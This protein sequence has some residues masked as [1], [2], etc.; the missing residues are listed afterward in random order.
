MMQ[1]RSIRFFHRGELVA[2]TGAPPDRTVLEW[3][4]EDAGCHG[5]KE[6]CAEGDCGAC[7]VIV[8]ALDPLSGLSPQQKGRR[9]DGLTLRTVN[10]CLQFLPM[11]DGK[12]LYTIEDLSRSCSPDQ[13]SKAQLHPVQEAMVACHGSQCGFCTPGFVMSLTAMYED[14]LEAG[15]QPGRR[16]IADGL[17]GNLCRCTGYRPIIDAGLASFEAPI[18]R[19]ETAS[20]IAALQSLAADPALHYCGPNRSGGQSS[21]QFFAPR[22]LDELAALRE[23]MPQATLLAG[24]TDIGLW[25]NKQFRDLGD[26]LS[27]GSVGELQRI[28]RCDTALTIGAGVSL[29]LAWEALVQEWPE[30]REV[31]LR[32]AGPPVRHSG[33][34]GGNLANGSPIGDGAPVLMALD[35]QLILRK[36]CRVRTLALDSFYL[37]YRNNQLE[38]GEFLQAIQIP[39]REPGTLVRAWKISK[40]YDSDIS[41]VFGAF[42]LRLEADRIIEA[43]F[44]FGGMA[45]IVKRASQT[46]RAV[47]GRPWTRPTADAAADALGEDFA[48]L[49]DLRASESYRLQVARAL[50]QRL[51]LQTRS[52]APLSA[53]ESSVWAT[54][55]AH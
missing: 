32:F 29:E 51:W 22:T 8:A 34:L 35:A 25:V 6:G 46:E 52:D 9:S 16:E 55:P 43:R 50:F 13:H 42:A 14:H 5:T 44:A 47:L 11:L 21:Q 15:T 24:A 23:Q 10:A 4:R 18:H 30:L 31:W 19:L 27:L 45:A 33:T 1:S 26:I 12:A 53:Q 36:G 40:R 28:E 38:A 54:S 37:G 41:A 2:L 48:P 20:T 17:A 3:L 49:S 39:H 7:V